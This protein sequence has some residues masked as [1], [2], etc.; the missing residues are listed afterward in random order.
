[1]F[2]RAHAKKVRVFESV[3][4]EN[5]YIYTYLQMRVCMCV[6]RRIDENTTFVCVCVYIEIIILEKIKTL[7]LSR[8][9]NIVNVLRYYLYKICTYVFVMTATDRL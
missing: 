1:M 2:A 8:W 3:V 9:P 6:D 4:R 5:I 7:S